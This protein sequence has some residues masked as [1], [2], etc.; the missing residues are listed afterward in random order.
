SAGIGSGSEF[1]IELPLIA[2]PSQA[3]DAAQAREVKLPAGPR[4]TVLV[5][6]D[7][8][9]AAMLLAEALST[10]G[11]RV[12]VANDG[13]SALELANKVKPEVVLLDIG[14]PVMDGY[15]VAKRLRAA[16]PR[17]GLRIVAIT[18][19][20]LESDRRNSTLQGFDAHLVKPVELAD[21]LGIIE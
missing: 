20:G 14:M 9:D 11:H 17:A 10:V 8:A 1:A 5:V 4:R 6:D 13:P 3:V 19:Y 15:E 21:L 18:G 16:P 12:E 2:K 7:N